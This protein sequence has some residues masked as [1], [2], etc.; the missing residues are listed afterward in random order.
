MGKIIQDIGVLRQKSSPATLDE[1]K[2]IIQ[3]LEET[4][5][6]TDNAVGIA[7]IQIGYPKTVGVVRLKDKSVFRLINP[8]LID[9]DD[10]FVY[11]HEG[12]LS[13]PNLFKNVKRYGQIFIR[14]YTL[15]MNNNLVEEKLVFETGM[16]G[17]TTIAI[18]HELDHFNG[19]LL[20]D[21]EEIKGETVVRE[22]PKVGRNEPC[23]CGSKLKYKKCCGKGK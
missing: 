2:T 20:I 22:S 15:G 1:A 7:A 3:E 14:N 8:E 6:M 23:P 17:D 9:G 16:D 19:K 13:F 12:C 11:F 10:E 5:K 18:Q 4:L 21:H